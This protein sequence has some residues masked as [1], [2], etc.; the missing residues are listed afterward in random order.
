[1]TDPVTSP[2]TAAAAPLTFKVADSPDEFD[3]IARLQYATFV[4]EIPQH[5]SN[6]NQLHVD[7]FHDENTYLIC[8]DGNELLGTLALR[9]RRPFALERRLADLDS[10]LPPCNKP[11][12][13]RLLATRRGHRSGRVF[14]GLARLLARHCTARGF[15]L[16]VISATV[17]QPRLYRH[18]GFV[19]FGP[20]VGTEGAV[21]QPMYLTTDAF[22]Q[23]VVPVL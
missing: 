19:P 18:L 21:Y 1:M 22:R 16:A 2:S 9:D 14:L 10:Y 11:C 15:D 6:A 13:I 3:Q 23:H 17:R 4:E 12:E 7:R 8:L 20:Q 5:P